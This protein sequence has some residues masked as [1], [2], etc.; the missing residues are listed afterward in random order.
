MAEHDDAAER[1]DGMIQSFRAQA[2]VAID[3]LHNNLVEQFLKP[4]E[5]LDQ[6]LSRILDDT[7]QVPAVPIFSVHGES[8]RRRQ[9]PRRSFPGASAANPWPLALLPPPIIAGLSTSTPTA[10][11][12]PHCAH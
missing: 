5:N 1:L 2:N 7:E 8:R 6:E 3:S 11:S 9:R 4:F 10:I 12:R